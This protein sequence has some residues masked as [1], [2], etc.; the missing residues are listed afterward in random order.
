MELPVLNHE[1]Y[2]AKC[3]RCGVTCHMP[4]EAG[5]VKYVIEELHC[6]FLEREGDGRYGCTVYENRFE[7]APWCHAAEEALA[8]G[9]LATDCP[10]A[11]HVPGYTGR[12]WAP[13][14]VR[15][16]LLPVVR[17]KLIAD[18]LPLSG[19]PDSALKILTGSGEDWTYSEQDSGFVFF[20]RA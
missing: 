11:A 4:V 8:T 16:K 7:K 10:Y 5:E 15:R 20:R 17:Q 14:D 1:Q 3:R 13:P 19:N 2:E 6:R 9:N 18:G 12:V